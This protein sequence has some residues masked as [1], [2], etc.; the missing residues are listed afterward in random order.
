MQEANKN[1]LK[2]IIEIDLKNKKLNQE[3]QNGNYDI[4]SEEIVIEE[5]E[6]ESVFKEKINE[7]DNNI[8]EREIS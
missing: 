4:T 6:I 7:I 8:K 3:W 5:N 2:R 1:D